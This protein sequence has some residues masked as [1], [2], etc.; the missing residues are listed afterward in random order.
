VIYTLQQR[1]RT[2][3]DPEVI[4][5]PPIEVI[6]DSESFSGKISS[7]ATSLLGLAA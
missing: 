6:E 5:A 3:L 1:R 4:G 7:T 2:G